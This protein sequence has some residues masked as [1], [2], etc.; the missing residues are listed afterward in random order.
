LAVAQEIAKKEQISTVAKIVAIIVTWNKQQHVIRC[1]DSVLASTY[2]IKK[3]IVVDNASSDGTAKTIKDR[4]CNS[5]IVELLENPKNLGGSGGF[6][7]GIKAALDH[8]PGY[9][10]LLDND[11][12]VDPDAL[13]NL[14]FVMEQEQSA[15]IVGSKVYFA[16]AP[17]IIWGLGAY[18]NYRLGHISVVGDKVKDSGQYSRVMKLDYVPMCSFLIS[19]EV[20]QQIGLVDPEYFVYSDDVDYCTRA[21]Q[22]GFEV[23]NA[24]NSVAWHDVTLHS[25]RLSPF[26]AYYFTRNYIYYFF[27]YTPAWY[28]PVTV[29]LMVLFL[30]RRLMAA[31]KYW[32][33]LK[34][35]IEINKATFAGFFDACRGKR[36]KVY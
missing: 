4:Y 25:Q 20:V 36:G 6:Y 9:L 5:T 17:E 30:I 12:T 11:V 29:L 21:K 10:W 24:P 19:T 2:P 26:A 35:Y 32:P 7:T 31:I 3:V 28:K 1:I 14:I 16:Q 22:A 23:Y 15:G 27:K 13:K 34:T 18:V 8:Q 33:G